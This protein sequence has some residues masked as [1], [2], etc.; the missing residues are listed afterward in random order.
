MKKN[1][2]QAHS[3]LSSVQMPGVT[4]GGIGN[5]VVSWLYPVVAGSYGGGGVIDGSVTQTGSNVE[6]AA[7]ELA[8]NAGNPT[9]SSTG[10]SVGGTA[11][12]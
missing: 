8:E 11:A 12:Y 1:K 7:Q 10:S 6:T 9:E 5:G 3:A 4:Y 2:K